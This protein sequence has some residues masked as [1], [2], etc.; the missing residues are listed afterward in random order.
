MR[1]FAL[2]LLLAGTA[3]TPA[4]AQ[5]HL[6]RDDSSQREERRSER[7]QS[8][9]DRSE[10][11]QQRVE[12]R[13]EPRVERIE[14]VDRPQ[15]EHVQR[16]DGSRDRPIF[17]EGGNS[18]DRAQAAAEIEARRA[19]LRERLRDRSREA[20]AAQVNVN[21]RGRPV[22]RQDGDQDSVANWRR[23]RGKQDIAQ[24][25]FD[26]RQGRRIRVP[27]GAR[28]DR[29][30]PL[31]QTAQHRDRRGDHHWRTDWRHDHRYDWRNHRRHHRSIFRL[32]FYFDPFG[33]GYH[34]YG[35]GW[36][37]WPSYYSN[38]YWLND[39]YQ[40]RLPYAPYPYRWV[41]YYD[42]ALL[43]NTFTGEVVDVIYDFFW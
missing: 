30:A 39:P 29:P 40:Y 10:A 32:G 20:D 9:E 3:F 19:N 15:V 4:L 27:E 22:I 25:R 6:D 8:H 17:N 18:A 28:P 16:V 21:E 43:V 31:P 26:E 12:V 13:Q 33:W 23:E 11:R 38:N 1:N 34:R 5:R 14:R 36:R 41:R 35:I 2:A 7:A 42:D 24:N 37:L